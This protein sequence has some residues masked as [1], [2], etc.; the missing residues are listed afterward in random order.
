MLRKRISVLLTCSKHG[1]Q[2]VCWSQIVEAGSSHGGGYT[3][4][5]DSANSLHSDGCTTVHYQIVRPGKVSPR[6]SVPSH[7]E[8]PSYALDSRLS[9]FVHNDW[10]TSKFGIE[11]KSEQQIRGMRDAC[12]YVYCCCMQYIVVMCEYSKFRIE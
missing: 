6:C 12:R 2:A 8:R 4:C 3:S 1:K 11:I 7:I 9:R 10:L 5:L